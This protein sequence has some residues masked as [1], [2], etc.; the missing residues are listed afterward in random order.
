MTKTQESRP[1][2]IGLTVLSALGR[3][4]PHYPN[5]TPLGGSWDRADYMVLWRSYTLARALER[6]GKIEEAI[7]ALEHI[8]TSRIFDLSLWAWP[9]CRAKLVELYQRAGRADEAKRVSN[10]LQQY[11]AQGD[12]SHPVEPDVSSLGDAAK[13]PR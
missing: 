5:V 4:L 7:S 10:E 3:L 11:L 2:A 6:Q 8:Q 13:G 1:L 9:Q 12:G